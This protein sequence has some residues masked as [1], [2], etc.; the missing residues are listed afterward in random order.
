M[1]ARL[2]KRQADTVKDAIKAGVIVQRLQAHV[3]GRI[4]LTNSQVR[5]GLGLLNKVLADQKAVDH[6][7]SGSVEWRLKL[8]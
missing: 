6:T 2:T 4:E 1:A 3:E 7:V 8:T 5:A